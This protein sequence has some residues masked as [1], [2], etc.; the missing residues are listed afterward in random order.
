MW[1]TVAGR[2][3]TKSAVK[4]TEAAEV[5]AIEPKTEEIKTEEKV[6]EPKAEEEK[7]PSVKKTTAKKATAETT[8]KTTK[9]ASARTTAKK[10]EVKSSLHVQCEDRN[11]TEA[12]LMKIAADVW[13]YDLKH[14]ASEL[15][16]IDLYVKLEESKVYYVMNGEAGSFGI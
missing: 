10:A 5:K 2:K 13:K 15:T 7:K 3:S 9:K 1:A 6:A 4:P 8:A 12:D 16:S 14:K 11:Y